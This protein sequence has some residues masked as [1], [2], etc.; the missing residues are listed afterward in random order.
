MA[1]LPSLSLPHCETPSALCSTVCV[2][3]SP[4]STREPSCW[5]VTSPATSS[6]VSG[7]ATTTSYWQTFRS[8]TSCSSRPSVSLLPPPA[9]PQGPLPAGWTQT[10][11]AVC[12]MS[13]VCVCVCVCCRKETSS[14]KPRSGL[15]LL[16]WLSSATDARLS[17]ETSS[18]TIWT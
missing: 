18:T 17:S 4:E 8:Q 5:S 3:C 9:A 15:P 11:V 6:T 1:L 2:P 13:C 16:V 12:D 7:R 10:G 14:L